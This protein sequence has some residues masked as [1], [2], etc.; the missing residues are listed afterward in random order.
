[1][2]IG[3]LN[4]RDFLIENAIYEIQFSPNAENFA[5]ENIDSDIPFSN[6]DTLNN[7][8]FVNFEEMNLEIGSEFSTTI[9]FDLSNSFDTLLNDFKITSCAIVWDEFNYYE[10]NCEELQLQISRVSSINK[11]SSNKFSIQ[12]NP[13]NNLINFTFSSP[14]SKPFKFTLY[15]STG[16]KVLFRE[17]RG[18]FLINKSQVGNGVFFF[19][20]NENG[21]VIERGKL[22]FQ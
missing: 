18:D 10:N 1:L 11:F 5:I 14:I 15:N 21:I 17:V 9:R 8:L 16:Q 2:E 3:F 19:E 7:S 13:S 22:I 20:M 4:E 12:P 6:F